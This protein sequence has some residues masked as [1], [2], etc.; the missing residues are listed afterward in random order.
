[1]LEK[2]SEACLA[3]IVF[4]RLQFW[5]Q[6]TPLMVPHTEIMEGCSTILIFSVDVLNFILKELQE[7]NTWK[8]HDV[9]IDVPLLLG[10][11]FL[12][13]CLVVHRRIEA[14]ANLAKNS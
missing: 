3:I 10:N 4:L 8:S 13:G 1:M 14:A 7:A 5:M 2:I 6:E 9:M 11:R 12:V